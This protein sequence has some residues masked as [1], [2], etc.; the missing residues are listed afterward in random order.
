MFGQF[1]EFQ[2]PS[3]PSSYFKGLSFGGMPLHSNSPRR[4]S[5]FVDQ[6]RD[7]DEQ[8][9]VSERIASSPYNQQ[10]NWR[11]NENSVTQTSNFGTGRSIER[12]PRF[13]QSKN[14]QEFSGKFRPSFGPPKDY[15]KEI[16]DLTGALSKA[17]ADKSVLVA[18][19][20]A[21][22]EK[23]SAYEEKLGQVDKMFNAM[24]SRISALEHPSPVIAG[25]ISKMPVVSR[26]S[27]PRSSI[28]NKSSPR[29]VS[30]SQ[31]GSRSGSLMKQR[32]SERSVAAVS[33]GRV[34]SA[35]AA[36]VV[37]EAPVRERS[38]SVGKRQPLFTPRSVRKALP[39][40]RRN[41]SDASVRRSSVESVSSVKLP[42]PTSP[43]IRYEVHVALHDQL[44]AK[45][46]LSATLSPDGPFLYIVQCELKPHICLSAADMQGF[47]GLS[48]AVMA[49]NTRT[50]QDNVIFKSHS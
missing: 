22:K 45:A 9:S 16:A 39:S 8:V 12:E 25:S 6:S 17:T 43:A 36:P 18:E 42:R 37:K 15:S 46:Q 29:S 14:A 10:M 30:A 2:P 35:R 27:S 47:E 28:S 38:A 24:M 26:L 11:S 31:P 7:I 48:I 20:G 19:N 50:R 34:E 33:R 13:A 1:K 32:V 21:L 40:D 23:I 41:E 44:V 5:G 4:D 49:T 3:A